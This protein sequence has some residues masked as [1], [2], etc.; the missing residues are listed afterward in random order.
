MMVV[1]HS[2]LAENYRIVHF[3]THEKT[4]AQRS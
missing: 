2:K 4:E 3:K 1:Q